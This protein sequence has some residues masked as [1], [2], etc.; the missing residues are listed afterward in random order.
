MYVRIR[1]YIYKLF[2]LPL[3]LLVGSCPFESSLKV[4]IQVSLSKMTNCVSK[5]SSQCE[6]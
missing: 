2:P 3:L 1:T 5:M 6:T 4:L